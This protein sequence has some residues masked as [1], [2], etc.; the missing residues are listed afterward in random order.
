MC[1]D[2]HTLAKDNAWTLEPDHSH[3]P[4]GIDKADAKF[5]A[6]IREIAGDAS[7]IT[8]TDGHCDPANNRAGWGFLAYQDGVKM[9][10]ASG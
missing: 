6:V 1:Y 10:E 7:M 9:A 3:S 8:A 5:E 2:H 4:M